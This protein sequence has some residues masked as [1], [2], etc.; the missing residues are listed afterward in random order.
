M[1]RMVF[2]SLKDIW[3]NK[4]DVKKVE[5]S[6]HF[7]KICEVL[8][9]SG[10]A[11]C[12]IRPSSWNSSP[13][14]FLMQKFSLCQKN[15]GIVCCLSHCIWISALMCTEGHQPTRG[16]FSLIHLRGNKS[17]MMNTRSL[18][19]GGP[20]TAE[21]IAQGEFPLLHHQLETEEHRV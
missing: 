5:C 17:G 1:S 8:L 13:I 7:G 4:F 21:N 16:S 12:N 2:F 18:L 3:R 15:K 9:L 10:R 20:G 11:F 14:Y 6:L 19:P